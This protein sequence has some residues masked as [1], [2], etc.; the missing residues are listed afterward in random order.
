MIRKI[1]NYLNIILAA[2]LITILTQR[3]V[4]NIKRYKRI[5]E[6]KK[7]LEE[8]FDFTEQNEANDIFIIKEWY[9]VDV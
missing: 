9:R 1:Q 2:L 5:R 8:L 6:E 7:L 4:N 3:L